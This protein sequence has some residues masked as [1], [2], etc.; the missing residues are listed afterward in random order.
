M[1]LLEVNSPICVENDIPTDFNLDY[2]VKIKDEVSLKWN[3]PA[4]LKF[5]VSWE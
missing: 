1:L 2:L 5:K 3:I 4:M